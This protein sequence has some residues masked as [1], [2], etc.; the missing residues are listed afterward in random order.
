MSEKGPDRAASGERHAESAPSGRIEV[1]GIPVWVPTG[2][3]DVAP[4]RLAQRIPS[5]EHAR[6]GILDN[7]K[8]FADLVLRGVAEVLQSLHPGATIRTW[9]KSYLGIASPFAEEMAAECDVVI[10]GVG[11]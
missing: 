3:A 1:G 10:N 6:I 7:H 11:H 4:R 5:L 8:E 2:T 9:Q